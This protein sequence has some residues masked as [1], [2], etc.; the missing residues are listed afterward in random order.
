MHC[1]TG[2]WAKARCNEKEPGQEFRSVF[3]RT[4]QGPLQRSAA[5]RRR[6]HTIAELAGRWQVSGR[7]VRRLIE[8]GKLRAVRIGDQLRVADDVLLRFEERNAT[9]PERR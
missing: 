6:Y 5:A 3:G 7:T 9:G 4:A 8:S 1:L 2:E